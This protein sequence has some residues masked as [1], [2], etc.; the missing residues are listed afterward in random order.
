[1]G[2]HL[3]WLNYNLRR[4]DEVIAQGRKTLELDPSFGETHWFLGLAYE[5]QRK[6][7]QA[8][9]ELQSAVEL[10]GRRLMTLS[11]L[12]HL[13]AVS[14]DRRAALKILAGIN[15]LSA[16]RYVP[17]YEKALIY[18]GIGDNNQAL[19]ELKEAYKE[20][21]YWMLNLQNDPRLDPLR[22]DARFQD[23]IRRVG[24]ARQRASS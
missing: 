23:L 4:Y 11:A 12:G 16:K 18:V 9:T 10:S 20:G 3:Q 21:S 8:A 24:V 7:K 13:L 19:A 5:Q 14:G 17:S 1:M 22:S 15:A 2:V 6:Y